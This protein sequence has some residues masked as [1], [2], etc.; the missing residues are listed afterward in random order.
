[1]RVY[2]PGDH[3]IGV[4]IRKGDRFTIPAGWLRISANPLLGRG[5][6]TKA[7]L[8]WFAKL[9]FL[10][11]HPRQADQ[12]EELITKND[13]LCVEILKA[14]DLLA[15]VDVENP[16]NLQQIYEILKDNQSSAE[17]F[18]LMFALFNSAAEEAIAEGDAKRAAWA[19]AGAE[20]FRSL[21]VFKQQLEQWFEWAIP[22][23][24]W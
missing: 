16:E 2:E 20:R 5:Q 10:A 4:K 24:G 22:Q 6:F 19:V 12:F 8:E 3:G 15:G 18:A 7:G 11:D 21:L 17:W 13:S 23:R 9:I 14:S 1:M